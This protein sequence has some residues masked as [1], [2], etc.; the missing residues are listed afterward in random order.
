MPVHI[1]ITVFEHSIGSEHFAELCKAYPENLLPSGLFR[2]TREPTDARMVQVQ[3]H[4]AEYG[5]RPAQMGES[6]GD[7][8]YWA[9]PVSVPTPKQ[10]AEAEWF[11]IE[12]MLATRGDRL[13][14]EE[15]EWKVEECEDEGD[16]EHW[17]ETPVHGCY[18]AAIMVTEQIAEVIRGWEA[19]ELRVQPVHYHTRDWSSNTKVPMEWREAGLEPRFSVASRL[20]LPLMSETCQPVH[21]RRGTPLPRGSDEPAAMR[22]PEGEEQ[23]WCYKQSEVEQMP[24]FDLAMTH[25]RLG[26]SSRAP[27][28]HGLVFSRRLTELLSSEDPNITWWPVMF[29]DE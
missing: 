20:T 13:H 26:N 12:N 10:L 3:K 25:E 6:S 18:G 8:V 29:E 17:Q 22:R 21:R 24:P 5:L 11:S 19:P 9:D 1:K 15:L 23:F 7:D 28:N 2:I 16:R 4:L 27:L 14:N